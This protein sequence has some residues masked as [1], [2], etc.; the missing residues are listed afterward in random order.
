VGSIK[1]AQMAV[2]MRLRARGRGQ[3][4]NQPLFLQKD[5]LLFDLGAPLH[6]PLPLPSLS[7]T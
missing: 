4:T 2:A 3:G 1:M 7:S 5:V 6:F